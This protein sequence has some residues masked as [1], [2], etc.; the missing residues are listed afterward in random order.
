MK[1]TLLAVTLTALTS[2]AAST[3]L[4]ADPKTSDLEI[5]GNVAL[6]SDYRFRGISQTNRDPALQGGFDLAHKS[7]LYAG[8]W[9]SNVSQWANPGGSMEIDFYVGFGTELPMGVGVDVGHTWYEYPGNEA[10]NDPA[11]AVGNDTR[12]LHIGFSYSI[13]SYKYSRASTTWFGIP[14]SKGSDYHSIGLEF[15]P[16]ENLTLS[17]SAGNQKVKRAAGQNENGFKDYSIGG[18]YDIGDGYAVGL[19]YHKVSF[20]DSAAETGWF[21]P[22]APNAGAE[23]FKSGVV[24]SV[25][26]SF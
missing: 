12:E 20:K 18:S 24:L 6:V 17:A 22:A 21:V 23:I 26:K 5:S 11:V 9:A 4:A 14:G 16:M 15:S 3:V 2:G 19:T 7:G 10:G 25:S 1:K 8:T 13:L